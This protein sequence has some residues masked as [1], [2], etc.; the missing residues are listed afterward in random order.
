MSTFSKR[1][2]WCAKMFQELFDNEVNEKI[3]NPQKEARNTNIFILNHN[4]R[5]GQSVL[6]PDD[7]IQKYL[8]STKMY[9]PQTEVRPYDPI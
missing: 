2:L 9:P 6:G 4:T 7:T 8:S 3:R 1:D 5:S